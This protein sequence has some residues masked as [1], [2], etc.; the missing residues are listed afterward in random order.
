MCVLSV[1][2]DEDEDIPADAVVMVRELDEVLMKDVG[3]KIA[4]SGK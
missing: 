4:Q 1:A 3:N 2:T